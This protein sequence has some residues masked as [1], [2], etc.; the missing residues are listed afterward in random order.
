MS[1]PNSGSDVVSMKLRADKKGLLIMHFLLA[2]FTLNFNV[3][4]NIHSSQLTFLTLMSLVIR[5]IIF[6]IFYLNNTH[7][8]ST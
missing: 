1:E 3:Y 2:P 8:L 6:D 7:I 4:S 5:S